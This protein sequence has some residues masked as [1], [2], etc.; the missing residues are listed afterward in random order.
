[1]RG[2]IIFITVFLIFLVITLIYPTLPPGEM[3][4]NLLNVP[5]TDYPVLGI[6]ATTLVIAVFN[7]VV[8]GF[9]AWLIFTLTNKIRR[10]EKKPAT[11]T[12]DN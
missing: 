12:T 3:L 9:I 10:K 1:M 11:G 2:A 8:Y 7:G 4:Y 5:E 6:P